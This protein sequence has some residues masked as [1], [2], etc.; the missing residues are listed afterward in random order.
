A[1]PRVTR[2]ERDL[3]R[4]APEETVPHLDLVLECERPHVGPARYRLSALGRVRLGRG[5]Q[6]DVRL[7]D[8]G[9]LDILGPDAWMSSRHAELAGCGD[10]WTLRDLPSLS[11]RRVTGARVPGGATAYVAD[12]ALVQLGHAFFRFLT[13]PKADGPPFREARELEGPEGSWSPLFADVVA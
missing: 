3:D 2:P 6:R 9:C 7:A 1:D 12:G 5:D 11:G 4:R 10:G 13:G 8:D